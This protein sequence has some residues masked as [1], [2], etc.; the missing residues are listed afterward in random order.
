MLN[1]F[2]QW[3]VLPI[4]KVYIG[5]QACKTCAN[6]FR[7]PGDYII[8]NEFAMNLQGRVP[9]MLIVVLKLKLKMFEELLRGNFDFDRKNFSNKLKLDFYINISPV[10]ILFLFLF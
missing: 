7:T 5:E 4:G 8:S 1:K 10:K 9:K 3:L 6:N 2:G